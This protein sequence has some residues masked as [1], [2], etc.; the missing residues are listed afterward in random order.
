[1]DACRRTLPSYARLGGDRRTREDCGGVEPVLVPV[2]PRVLL[3]AAVAAAE[4]RAGDP[5]ATSLRRRRGLPPRLPL[6]RLSTNRRELDLGRC[7][8]LLAYSGMADAAAG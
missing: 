3:L 8:G 6:L 7:S 2:R 5:A 4:V 1:M